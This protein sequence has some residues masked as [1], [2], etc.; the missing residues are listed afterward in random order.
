MTE[1]DKQAGCGCVLILLIATVALWYGAF[2][3]IRPRLEGVHDIVVGILALIV[4]L[5][6]AKVV[7]WLQ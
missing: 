2:V 6:L 5:A 3:T 1:A 4:V 7:R